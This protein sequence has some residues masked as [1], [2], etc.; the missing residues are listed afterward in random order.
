MLCKLSN[1]CIIITMLL[2]FLA[3]GKLGMNNGVV[4]SIADSCKGGDQG[5]LWV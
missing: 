5:K 4:A 2:Q 3:C 1:V